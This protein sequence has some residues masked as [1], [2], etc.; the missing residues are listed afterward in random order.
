LTL[1][2]PRSASSNRPHIWCQL[3]PYFSTWTL[4]S[5]HSIDVRSIRC[6]TVLFWRGYI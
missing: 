1:S 3:L 2:Y 6:V 4:A 5:F